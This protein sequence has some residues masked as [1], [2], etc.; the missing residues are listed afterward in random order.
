MSRRRRRE[1]APEPEATQPEEPVT[2]PDCPVCHAGTM[3]PLG[4]RTGDP[5]IDRWTRCD[6]PACGF[7]SMTGTRTCRACGQPMAPAAIGR[8]CVHCASDKA[9]RERGPIETRRIPV[10]EVARRRCLECGRIRVPGPDG[11]PVCATV[12]P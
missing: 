2:M 7:M 4:G 12:T 1:I 5:E 3:R 10:P 6:R 11:C 8:I 9:R